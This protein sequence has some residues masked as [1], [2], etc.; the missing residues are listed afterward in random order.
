VQ[1]ATSSSLTSRQ[2]R[3]LLQQSGKQQRLLSWLQHSTS[4]CW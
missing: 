4:S 1:Q 2:G 3:T